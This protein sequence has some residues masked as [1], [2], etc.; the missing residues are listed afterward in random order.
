[1][2]GKIVASN[3]D[4]VD[5]STFA[6]F[7]RSNLEQYHSIPIADMLCG[8]FWRQPHPVNMEDINVIG[9]IEHSSLHSFIIVCHKNDMEDL[10]F[11]SA[12]LISPARILYPV[13]R[14]FDKGIISKHTF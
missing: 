9:I 8:P 1:M 2:L 12:H 3:T 14:F 5:P 4:I 11:L 6:W 10:F 7:T 13:N